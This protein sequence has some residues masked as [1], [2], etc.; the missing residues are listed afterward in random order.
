MNQ[1]PKVF[2]LRLNGW[3]AAREAAIEL[4]LSFIAEQR[5]AYALE[6]VTIAIEVMEDGDVALGG[7]TRDPQR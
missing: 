3:A 2:Q 4:G 1:W 7:T 6:K 5:M